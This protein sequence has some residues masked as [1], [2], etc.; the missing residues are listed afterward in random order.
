MEQIDRILDHVKD[1]SFETYERHQKTSDA[2]ERCMSR[3]SEACS[4]L[5]SYLDERYP[6]TPWREMRGYGNVL[7]HRYEEV[8]HALIWATIRDDLPKLRASAEAELKRLQSSR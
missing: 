2:V 4:K 5:G 3:I 6:G 8:V 7:R 1:H